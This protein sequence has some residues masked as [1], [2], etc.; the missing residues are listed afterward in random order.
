MP[1]LSRNPQSEIK[2]GKKIYFY[3]NGIRNAIIRDFSPLPARTDVGALWE[4]LFFTE[5]LKQHAFR[6]DGA[7]IFFWRTRQQHEVD[8]LEVHNGKVR[9]FE[10]KSSNKS[11]T[12]SIRAFERAY[13]D[14]PVTIVTPE[15]IDVIEEESLS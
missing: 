13:P 6:C 7:E 10:C 14:T 3:D 12:T 2:L 1:S 4:N 8:F 15:N 5:R 11:K 9:A